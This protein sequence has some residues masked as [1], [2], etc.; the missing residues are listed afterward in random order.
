MTGTDISP[1][2]VRLASI[3]LKATAT[4]CFA[5]ICTV[6][7]QPSWT[8]PNCV[9]EL[10]DASQDW[11]F[12]DNKF[13]FIHIRLMLGS[14]ED[15]VKLY[16]Q[17]Y[18]CL[19]PGGWLEHS[20]FSVIFQSDDGSVPEDSAYTMWNQFFSSAGEATRRTFHVTEKGRNVEW[21]KEAG[22]PGPVH[23]RN[24]KLPVGAWPADKHWKEIVLFNKASIEQGLEGY[25]L[26]LGTNVLG[27]SYDELQVLLGKVR[28]AVKNRSYH[29]YY[30]W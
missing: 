13:D 2:Q 27:W 30:P 17:A 24:F 19:K 10:D 18:R 6:I 15:W 16:K 11:A 4:R 3:F 20:D 5:N 23:T 1:I 22:F 28:Q 26:Y 9:F 29:A 12:A 21:I 8:P 25:A 7:S 14:I